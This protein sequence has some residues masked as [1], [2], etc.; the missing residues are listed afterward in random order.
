MPIDIDL[1]SAGVIVLPDSVGSTA[2]PHLLLGTGKVAILYLLDQT[3]MGRSIPAATWDVQESDSCSSLPNTT[4]LDGGILRFCRPIGNGNIYVTGQN[5]PL[6][7]FT[8]A[9]GVIATPQS[10]NSANRFPPRGAIPAVSASGTTNGIVWILDLNVG[11]P[12]GPAILDAYDAP[13]SRTCFTAAPQAELALPELPLNFTLPTI[14][15][16]NVTS[17]VDFLS[18]FGFAAKLR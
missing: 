13:T 10:A 2:H 3:N 11:H 1:G 15:N 17:A 18:F 4:Q 6:S 8:I 12:T 5:F 9:S 16:A 7:Q 14:A